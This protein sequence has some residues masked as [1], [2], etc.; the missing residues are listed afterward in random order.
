MNARPP[1]A[2]LPLTVLFG[3]IA[4][5]AATAQ[6]LGTFRWQLQ[7]YCNVVSVTV[8]QQGAQ[9]QLDGTDDQCGA[10]QQASVTGLAY[11]NPD[12]S[13]GFGLNLVAA[14]GGLPVHVTATIALATLSGTW[15][16]SAGA[17]GAFVFTPG[18]GIGGSA[19][20]SARIGLTSIDPTQVQTRVIGAC[21]AGQLMTGVNQDGTVTC[22]AVAAATGGDITAVFAGTG[23]VGGSL[24]GDATLAVSF[25]GDG[26]AAAAAAQR[27]RARRR[28]AGHQYADRGWCAA[29]QH[30][31]LGR[32][33]HRVAGP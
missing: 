18:A 22:Q 30:D 17:T 10:G 6:P 23:L 29:G 3:L 28:A 24:T 4:A 26:A 9:Y 27:P 31:G 25:A 19:R 8:V 7:P 20:P 32:D 15:Q 11:L 14:P 1:F 21:P 33:R 5:T 16:D 12:G 2:S 13:I